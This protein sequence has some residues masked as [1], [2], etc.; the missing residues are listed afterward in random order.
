MESNKYIGFIL[1][2]NLYIPFIPNTFNYF[3]L[4]L[5]DITYDKIEL[6]FNLNN[7]LVKNFEEKLLNDNINNEYRNLLKYEISKFFANEY[8]VYMKE[9][10]HVPKFFIKINEILNGID[11]NTGKEINIK[12]KRLLLYK[13]FF[14]G[15]S[16]LKPL[17][18]IILSN[19][20]NEIA[21]DR[22]K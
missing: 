8:N 20:E 12:Y 5:S 4:E 1:K 19:Y 15:D 7:H 2:N 16:E 10:N 6:E 18:S 14:D 9:D 17:V 22:N 13:L 3:N 21:K 11:I